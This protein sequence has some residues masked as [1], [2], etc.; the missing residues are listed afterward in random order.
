MPTPITILTGFLGSGKTTLLNNILRADHGLR[1][2]VLVNDFGE[3][4]IDA[5]LIVGIEGEKISLQN[6]CICCTI[7]GDLEEAVLTLIHGPEPPEYIVIEASGVSDPGAVALTFTLSPA[8][9]AGV[10]VDSILAVVDAEQLLRLN[11][12]SAMLARQQIAVADM[13]VLNKVDLV[14]EQTL[15]LMHQMLRDL[16]PDVRILETTF[17]RVPLELVLGVGR[18]ALDKLTAEPLDVHVHPEHE[19]DHN[20][21]HEHEHGHEHEHEHE[22]HHAH[23][24]VHE[25]HTLVFNTWRYTHHEPFAYHTLYDAIKSLPPNIFRAKGI[26]YIDH[27]RDQRGVLQVAGTR[28]R[29]TREQDWGGQTPRTDLVFI[30]EEGAIDPA[31]LRARFDA[32]LVHNAPPEPSE[33]QRALQWVRQ[34]QA[35]RERELAGR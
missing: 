34:V 23:H 15:R 1:M 3:V 29:L 11:G 2:A 9:R 13:L 5:Q 26:V 8:L 31:E 6:G 19:H 10:Q 24:H 18:Y 20:H 32:C 30:G 25:D 4:N 22:H 14:S 33:Y 35:E 12:R 16:V 21:E 27:M 17:G 28:V 7:R